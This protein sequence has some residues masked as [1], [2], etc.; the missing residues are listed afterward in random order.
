MQREQLVEVR[1]RGSRAS[2]NPHRGESKAAGSGTATTRMRAAL[3]E[4]APLKESSSARHDGRVD[5]QLA[6]VER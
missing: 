4:I 3:A 6:A 1:Q 2:Q 5:A